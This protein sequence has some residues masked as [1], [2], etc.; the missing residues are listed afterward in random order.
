MFKS[1]LN[2]LWRASCYTFTTAQRSLPILFD[3]LR[4]RAVGAGTC[5]KEKR[6][7]SY[8]CGAQGW[9]NVTYTTVIPRENGQDRQRLSV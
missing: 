9:R 7:K 5:P 8:M 6:V 3:I 1:G 2:S 4:Y